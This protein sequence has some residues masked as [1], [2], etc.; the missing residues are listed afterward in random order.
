M[1]WRHGDGPLL[2]RRRTACEDREDRHDCQAQGR[3]AT[4][5]FRR[6][7]RAGVPRFM[8]HFRDRDQ[9]MS[10]YAF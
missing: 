7:T 10:V 3:A 6:A 1:L 4:A 8:S 2:G 9:L 5:A